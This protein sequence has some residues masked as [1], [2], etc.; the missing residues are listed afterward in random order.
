MKSKD[1][2]YTNYL[3]MSLKSLTESGNP[4]IRQKV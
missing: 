2:P 1:I 3:Q 4:E